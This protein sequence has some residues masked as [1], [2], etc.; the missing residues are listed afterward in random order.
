MKLTQSE[1]YLLFGPDTPG[2]RDVGNICTQVVIKVNVFVSKK[3]ALLVDRLD[4]LPLDAPGRNQLIG[5][6]NVLTEL[7]REL[8]EAP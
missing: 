1:L 4:A 7:I 2:P 3:R 6:I 8:A 5:A